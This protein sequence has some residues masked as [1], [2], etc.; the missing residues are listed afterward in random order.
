MERQLVLL[1]DTDA[2]WRLD[3]QTRRRGLQGVADARIALTEA[4]RRKAA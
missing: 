3:D 1:D 2:D 4:L